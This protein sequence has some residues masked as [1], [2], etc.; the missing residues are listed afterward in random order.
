L[1]FIIRNSTDASGNLSTAKFNKAVESLR[2]NGRLEPI[3]GENAKT[4]MDLVE[5]GRAIEARPRGSFVNESNTAVAGASMI[6]ENAPAILE[7]IPYIGEYVVKPVKAGKEFL[8]KRRT[9][10]DFGIKP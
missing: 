9:V 1:D 3:F 8:E 10:K 7:N 5:V 2:L 4:L 6:K